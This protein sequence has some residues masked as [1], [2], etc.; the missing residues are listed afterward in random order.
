MC[1][2][3][4]LEEFAL[5]LDREM[6]L[7][8]NWKHFAWEMRVHEDVIKRLEQFR[9]HSPTI[10]LFEY[11]EVTQPQLKIQQLTNALQEIGRKDLFNLLTTKGK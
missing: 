9:D 3:E 2:P 11:L 5:C 1:K 7:I 10:R 6:R 8:P 4:F